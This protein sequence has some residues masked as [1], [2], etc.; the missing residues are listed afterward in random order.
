MKINI[1]FQ[2]VYHSVIC[3]NKYLKVTKL[4]NK[5]RMTKE[6]VEHPFHRSPYSH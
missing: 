4:P 6:T 5:M 1:I 2:S 3:I